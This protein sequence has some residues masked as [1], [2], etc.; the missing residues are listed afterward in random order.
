MTQQLILNHFAD[1][2][3]FVNCFECVESCTTV[4]L[5]LP[6]SGSLLLILLMQ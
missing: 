4:L 2:M 1:V 5:L 3:T 6:N